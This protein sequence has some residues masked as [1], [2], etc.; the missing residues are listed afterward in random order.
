MTI[1]KNTSLAATIFTLTLFLLCSDKISVPAGLITDEEI[2]S[3]VTRPVLAATLPASWDENWFASP[4][5]LDLDN[6]GSSEII[7]SRH[8][9]L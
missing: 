2:P 4:A 7:V 5:V 1:Y 8:S 9:V 3:A 6:D